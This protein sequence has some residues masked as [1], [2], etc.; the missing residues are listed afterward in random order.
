MAVCLLAGCTPGAARA[1][2]VELVIFGAA[3]LRDALGAVETAYEATHAGVTITIA[4]DS[5]AALRTQIEQGAPADV[6]L[7]ADTKNPVALA[8]AGLA[9]GPPVRF[10]SNSLAIITPLEGS[11][12][13]DPADLAIPGLRIIAAGEDVPITAYA[14]AA[15]AAIAAL[16]D[17]P[18]GFA[19]AYAANVVSREDNVR[20]IVTKVELGEGDAG[21]VYATDAAASERVRTVA[22]PDAAAVVAAYSGVVVASSGH[23]A[24]GRAFLDWLTAEAGQAVLGELG[25]GAPAGP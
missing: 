14:A 20:A 19:G 24:E 3:S 11:P 13:A 4:T 5:S 10:A 6:F 8:D 12:V 25:F 7:S 16:P 18:P 15:V 9:D 22:I 23:R 2:Q 21:I 17:A 1:D